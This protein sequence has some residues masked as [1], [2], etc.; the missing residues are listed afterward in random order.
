MKYIRAI[1]RSFIMIAMFSLRCILINFFED[2]EVT[3]F[4]VYSQYI[5]IKP[6][7]TGNQIVIIYKNRQ[8]HN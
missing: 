2:R 3:Y 6:K 8:N 1:S 4:E 5:P 7:N